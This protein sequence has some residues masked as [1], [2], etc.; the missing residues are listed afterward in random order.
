[1]YTSTVLTEPCSS[2]ATMWTFFKLWKSDY[3]GDELWHAHLVANI[4]KTRLKHALS[5]F[6]FQERSNGPDI[7]WVIIYPRTSVL[8]RI[9]GYYS[10]F[11]DQKYSWLVTGLMPG[12]KKHNIKINPVIFFSLITSQRIYGFLF[13]FCV[14]FDDRPVCHIRLS[15]RL[16]LL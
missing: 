3:N 6:K 12:K 14:K 7:F 13:Y 4:K 9:L 15:L 2:F 5:S 16:G 1:M 10:E 8:L 11:M